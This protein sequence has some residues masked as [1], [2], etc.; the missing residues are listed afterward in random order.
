VGW[1]ICDERRR[2]REGWT[3]ARGCCTLFSFEF[4]ER[5][6]RGVEASFQCKVNL[7]VSAFEKKGEKAHFASKSP[8]DMIT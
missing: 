8:A 4:I 3:N 5:V 7:K 2:P 6:L 1:G